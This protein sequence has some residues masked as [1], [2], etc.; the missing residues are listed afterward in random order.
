[1]AVAQTN[2][3]STINVNIS[4]NS[5]TGQYVYNFNDPFSLLL[6]LNNSTSNIV[7]L[8]GSYNNKINLLS[9]SGVTI[10]GGKGNNIYNVSATA[11]GLNGNII[12]GSTGYDFITLSG[13]NTQIDLT[14]GARGVEA[15]VGR[16]GLNG[17]SVTVSLNQLVSSAVTNGGAGRAFAAVI[18]STGAVNV[19]E[20]GKFHLVGVVDS[21]SNGFDASGNAITGTALTDLLNSVTQISNITG[22]LAS[23]YAGSTTG[24]VPANETE[25]ANQLSAYVF[26]DG[27]KSYTIWTDGTVTPTDIKGNVL[28]P[29]YHPG[30][31]TPAQPFTYGSV[32]L[33]DKTTDWAQ[34]TL[35]TDV[36]GV[37]TIKLSAGDTS[38]YSAIALKAG[39]TGT[40]VV[41]DNGANG[42]NWFGL[43]QSGGGNHIVGSKGGNLFDLQLSTSLQDWLTGGTGFDIV[44]AVAAGADVDL[45][46]NNP[47]GHAAT[48]IDAV[49]GSANLSNTQT[50][51]LDLTKLQYVTDSTGAKGAVFEALLG[52][53]DDVLTLSGGGRWLEV[54][55]FAPGST[56]PAHAAALAHADLLDAAFGSHTHTA[57]NSLTGYLFE[58]LDLHGNVL[59]YV[60]VY[61]D[62]TID[63]LLTPPATTPAALDHIVL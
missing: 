1:V 30:A 37:S 52:S 39:V 46:A 24:T 5:T 13:S 14:Q 51:E 27:T 19:L 10:N 33:F 56:L 34:A 3:G 54:S 21:A 31:A 45:T 62:A 9:A 20:T 40:K 49:V 2:N 55:T 12:H 18:G 36:N 11:G 61:T 57:E 29:V 17:E 15:V 6:Y 50:V 26:S 23:L 32:A 60:T 63:S 42:Q 16:N 8:L 7:S 41:G 22:N 59:K 28:A 4:I 43:G 53:V 35:S 48:G 58:Q 44:K 25:V 38:A 47:S